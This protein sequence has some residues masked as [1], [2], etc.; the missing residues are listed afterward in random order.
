[1]R[2]LIT[3]L[4]VIPIKT[5]YQFNNE[6]FSGRVF[7][8]ALRQFVEFD[9]MLVFL[10]KQAKIAT[11]PVLDDLND[12][13]IKPVDIPLGRSTSEM[14]AIFDKILEQVNEDDSV[15]FDITHGLRSTPF[16][17]FLFAAFL[18]FARNVTIEAVYYGAYELGKPKENIPA[19]VFDLSE[20]V[21]MFD[22]ITAT[23]R[24]VFTGD[25]Q[26]LSNLLRE[27]IPPGMQMAAELNA[28]EVGDHLKRSAHE[29][30]NISKALR[31]T[32]PVEVMTSGFKI[33]KT[34][35]ETT[36]TLE[37][38]ARPFKAL[39]EK[40]EETYSNFVLENPLD[41]QEVKM[42]LSRSKELIVWYLEHQQA[43]NACLMMREWVIS[44]YMAILKYFPLTVHKKRI[45]VESIFY[46][47]VRD[48]QNNGNN[49]V[50]SLH[51]DLKRLDDPIRCIKFW[52][53][54]TELRNDNA[55]CGYREHAKTASQ[56]IND[57]SN[58]YKEFDAISKDVLS[59]LD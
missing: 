45:E 53:R 57:A 34:L 49:F 26:L 55:H 6:V 19:P 1:M 24:F 58:Y 50:S 52:Q 33:T 43:S 38:Y 48:L 10:T 23:N 28:K 20:F 59:L 11:W 15:I 31:M 9:Q 39:G 25:G 13:R 4:G 56:L 36:Q 42:H 8:E 2:K 5:Q 17:M 3:F 54:I 30:E 27:E 32:R 46:H 35:K 51:P 7:L 22:W 12:A 18:K 16:L 29:I 37:N 40:I 14:W 47:A 44:A 41:S 21:N